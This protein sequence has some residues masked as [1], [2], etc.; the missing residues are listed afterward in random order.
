[1][2]PGHCFHHLQQIN[3]SGQWIHSHTMAKL[4]EMKHPN[5]SQNI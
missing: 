5:T 2:C 1:M 4:H 3:E